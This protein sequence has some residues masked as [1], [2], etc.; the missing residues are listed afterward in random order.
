MF[1]NLIDSDNKKTNS[2]KNLK[3]KHIIRLFSI[4][5]IIILFFQKFY[6]YE[7][8]LFTNDRNL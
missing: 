2:F 3:Y 1:E 4:L 7:R 5:L 6:A 8:I